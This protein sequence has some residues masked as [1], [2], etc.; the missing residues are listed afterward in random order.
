MCIIIINK[1]RLSFETFKTCYK[2][3]PDSFGIGFFKNNV[4][5]VK[6]FDS[7]NNVKL[8]DV[9]NYYNELFNKYNN[10]LLHFRIRTSGLTTKINTQPFITNNNLLFAHNGIIREKELNNIYSDSYMFNKLILKQLPKGF[11]NQKHFQVLLLKYI[12]YSKIAFFNNKNF[13]YLGS[14]WINKDDNLFSNST[15][16]KTISYN[17]DY[18]YGL[19]KGYN[20]EKEKETEYKEYKENKYKYEYFT[21]CDKCGHTAYRT[22]KVANDFL[23]YNCFIKVRDYKKPVTVFNSKRY[24]YYCSICNRY[25]TDNNERVTGICKICNNEL[26]EKDNAN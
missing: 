11:E 3:N 18:N 13:V 14:G 15:Y 10:L 4:A 5:T 22:Y 21:H 12:G 9:Y 8:K 2:N 7:Y 24:Y 23:C 6:K 19:W 17:Y 16:E 25:I 1:K 26:N 20:E